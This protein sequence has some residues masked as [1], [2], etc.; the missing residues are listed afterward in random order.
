MVFVFHC[1][2]VTR[3]W[4]AV[5][6]ESKLIAALS[7]TFFNSAEEGVSIFFVLS[8]FLITGLL[9]DEEKATGSFSLKHFYLRRIL[10]VWPLLYAVLIFGF[11]I[12]PSLAAFFGIPHSQDSN[13]WMNFFLLNNFDL[14]NL[15]MS[16]K[17]RFNLLIEITWSVAIEEQFYLCWPLLLMLSSKFRNRGMMLTG[18]LIL[19]LF[20][21]I[22]YRDNFYYQYFHTL[23]VSGDLLTGALLAYLLRT[24]AR[25]IPFLQQQTDRLRLVLYALGMFFFV[26][27]YFF[28]DYHED[29]Y[30]LRYPLSF[31]YAY[32]IADQCYAGST[33]LKLGKLNALRQFGK[34]TYGAYLLHPIAIL[35]I[36][37]LLDFSGFNYK[38]SWTITLLLFSL[39]LITTVGLSI[40]SFHFFE[41]HFL[42]LKER[43]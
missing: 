43:L 14:M 6:H 15:A 33:F 32:V 17:I 5:H 12:Y 18:M 3:T 26:F 34:Y 40:M 10:R 23:A 19:N 28:F 11:F 37:H 21:R 4:Y 24:R 41:K 27:R 25:L 22:V 8:G 2:P 20:F 16:E 13:P 39:A 35:F 42:K 29:Y 30:L 1:F 7:E 38:D 9:L 36:K 31:F